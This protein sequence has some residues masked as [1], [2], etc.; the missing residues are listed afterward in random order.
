MDGWFATP[1]ELTIDDYEILIVGEV[2]GSDLDSTDEELLRIAQAARAERFRDDTRERRIEIA[3]AAEER[4]G[5]KVSWG[6]RVGST[7]RHFTTASVPVMTR[8]HLRQRR[9]L[10]T[11]VEAGIARSRSEALAWCVELV[12]RNE[13]EWIS[14]L[15]SAIDAVAQAREEGPSSER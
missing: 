15:R 7:Q 4:F 12:G 2:D 9:T 10:D 6:V 11:L 14:R 8:L 13:E 3:S 1:P 5:R